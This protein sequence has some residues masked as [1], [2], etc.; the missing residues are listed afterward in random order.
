MGGQSRAVGDGDKVSRSMP[1]I[2][3]RKLGERLRS[4]VRCL[5]RARAPDTFMVLRY[6]PGQLLG[7][8]GDGVGVA[9]PRAQADPA[10]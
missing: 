3:F 6:Q 7:W 1:S 4:R 10:E 9:E 8:M 5:A 2:R